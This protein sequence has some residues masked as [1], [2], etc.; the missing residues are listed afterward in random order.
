MT[1]NYILVGAGSAGCVL[2]NRLTENPNI[3]VLL[4]EAGGTDDHPEIRIPARWFNLL[5]TPI[6]WHYRTEP[7][8]HLDNR[9]LTLNRGKVLGGSS[10][11]NAMVYIRGHRWDYD[12]WAE[13]GAA[14]WS[15]AEVLPYFKKAENQERGANEFHGVGGPLNVADIPQVSPIA[16]VF[17]EACMQW[18]LP[19]NDDFNGPAQEGVGWYQVTQKNGERHSA[20][21]AYLKPA[22]AR[23][24][25]SL[26]TQ[27]QVTRVL[28]SGTLAIGVEYSQHGQIKQVHA[29]HE[30][31]LCGGAINS[32]QIL[33][34]SGLGPANQLRQFNLP[35]VVDLPGVGENFQ[36]HPK[37]DCHFTSRP[38]TKADF[39]LT[40]A[41]YADYQ[42]DRSGLLSRVRSPVGAFA[43]TRPDLSIPD[44]QYYAAQGDT[45]GAHDF[46]IVASLLRPVSR[47]TLTL[48]SAD[49]FSYPCI[50]P[51]FLACD[52]D[53]RVLLDSVKFVRQ[54]VHMPAYAGF[55]DAEL[56]P[57][58]E[59]GTDA[60]IA[61]WIRASLESTWHCAGTCKMGIDSMAVVTP[62]L[63]VIGVE[64]LRVV[65]ASIMPDIVG[66]NTNAAVI[67]IAEKA[68]DLIRSAAMS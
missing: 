24:N 48:R 1:V 57:P 49:P 3:S 28:F 27:A 62:Q 46:A 39:S 67:M 51:N 5:G 26:E 47:G 36:D 17:I 66:G 32:P 4:L 15:Y 12:H 16:H 41:A 6:D 10:S 29:D 60:E 50:Q 19:L 56:S 63:Q 34:C 42:R 22:L 58:H 59:V 37:V 68:A 31:I 53:P 9:V 30:V 54:L 64:N 7:Q 25:L 8:V 18:G 52:E 61:G 33:L 14:G 43:R 11:I 44:M 55:L 23:P 20:V 40:G 45:D 65:D 21:D 38:P 13:L 2:A 35:V